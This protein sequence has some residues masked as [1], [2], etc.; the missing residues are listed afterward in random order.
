MTKNFIAIQ[1][2]G[3]RPSYGF[4]TRMTTWWGGVMLIVMEAAALALALGAYLYLALKSPTWP[5][6]AEPPGLFWSSLLTVVMVLSLVPATMAKRAANKEDTPRVRLLLVALCLLGLVV[7]G[8]RVMEFTTLNVAWDDNAY[9]SLVWFI[10]G[11]HTTHVVADLIDTIF[12][13]AVIFTG[14]T[15]GKRLSAV[16]D[17]AV[18]VYFVVAA[19]IPVYVL[20]YW[21]PRVWSP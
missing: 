10:L 12:V 9:G 1:D 20:L 3:D 18:F 17:D 16:E 7:C 21:F 6:S 5:L 15:S 14:H 13:T 4:G 19:W 8:L 2:V 11:I